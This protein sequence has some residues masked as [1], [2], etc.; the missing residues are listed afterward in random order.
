MDRERE[1]T[2]SA[3]NTSPH[4]PAPLA[5]LAAAP[6]KA[7]GAKQVRRAVQENRTRRVFL[8]HDADPAVTEPLEALCR[9]YGVAVETAY[10]LR[11]LGKACG[12]AVGAS[13]AAG[14]E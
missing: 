7:V 14:T 10:T 4:T 3:P 5:D 12:I 8:A 2:A 13:A 1:P 6:K 11:Q 9:E